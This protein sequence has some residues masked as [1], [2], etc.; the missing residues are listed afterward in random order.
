M[1]YIGQLF[2]FTKYEVT[3]TAVPE[4][5]SYLPLARIL[6]RTSKV[7]NPS[8]QVEDGVVPDKSRFEV[9]PCPE[10]DDPKST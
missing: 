2:P 6:V 1:L 4:D 3:V 5:G 10:T 9:I 8:H 7:A